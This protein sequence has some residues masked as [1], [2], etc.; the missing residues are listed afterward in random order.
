MSSKIILG[1]LFFFADPSIDNLSFILKKGCHI[2]NLA[3]R[4]GMNP[5]RRPLPLGLKA[6]TA[7]GHRPRL[8]LVDP[9]RVRWST[10]ADGHRPRL[11]RV[12][13]TV[14]PPRTKHGGPLLHVHRVVNLSKVDPDDV[15]GILTRVF[16]GQLRGPGGAGPHVL[17]RPGG[18]LGEGLGGSRRASGEPGGFRLLE[19]YEFPDVRG[20]VAQGHGA[21]TPA[22]IFR[23]GAAIFRTGNNRWAWSG[24]RGVARASSL[25][26][27]FSDI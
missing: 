1:S 25:D 13:D 4:R 21:R 5:G 19:V 14:R 8:M 26:W 17:A 9:R 22:A 7:N 16:E 15:T 27:A 20:F 23:T 6:H 10:T 12:A 2:L 18:A 3:G 11:D 24:A